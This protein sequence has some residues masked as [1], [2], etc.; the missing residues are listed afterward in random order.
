MIVITD[1]NELGDKRLNPEE[2]L[3]KLKEENAALIENRKLP[4]QSELE[5]VDSSLGRPLHFS[6]FLRRLRAAGA[7]LLVMDGLPGNVAVYVRKQPQDADYNERDSKLPS[8]HWRNFHRYVT[9]FPK[10]V[11]AEFSVIETDERGLPK[12]EIRGWRSALMALIKAGGI[13]YRAAI[14][15]FHEPSGPRAWRWHQQLRSERQHG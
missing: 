2:G 15:E 3:A 8:D 4:Y 9:G 10:Q 11:L 12:R 7:Q 1:R 13:S 14:H 6:E 5:D